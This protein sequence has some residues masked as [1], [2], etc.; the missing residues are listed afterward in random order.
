M[1]GFNNFRDV[2]DLVRETVMM[3]LE[4]GDYN[5]EGCPGTTK[6]FTPTPQVKE[7]DVYEVG[8]RRGKAKPLVK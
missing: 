6:G 3:D 8:T 7:E 4:G 2:I 5:A 1:E